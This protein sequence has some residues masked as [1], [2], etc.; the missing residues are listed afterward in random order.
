MIV[1][2][3]RTFD[4]DVPVS[5]RGSHEISFGKIAKT[6]KTLARSNSTLLS[7]RDRA[8]GIDPIVVSM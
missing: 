8:I 3:I 7:W 4:Y 1:L 2:I 6:P 5:L